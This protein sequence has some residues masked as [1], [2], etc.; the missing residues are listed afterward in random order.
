MTCYKKGDK[1]WY[2][3]HMSRGKAVFVQHDSEGFPKRDAILAI[4]I[5]IKPDRMVHTFRWPLKNIERR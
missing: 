3:S 1:V 2:A 4:G 5:G